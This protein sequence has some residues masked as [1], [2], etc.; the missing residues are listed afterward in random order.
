VGQLRPQSLQARSHSRRAASP[1]GLHNVADF[2]W[3][4]FDVHW[5]AREQ[6]WCVLE[7]EF[8]GT[9]YWCCF[10]TDDPSETKDLSIT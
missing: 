2:G 8:T 1:S 4:E 3:S 10:G 7:L 9:R 5:H 6:L